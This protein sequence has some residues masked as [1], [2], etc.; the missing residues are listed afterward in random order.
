MKGVYME[1]NNKDRIKKHFKEAEQIESQI[2]DRKEH[3]RVFWIVVTA[4][5][6]LLLAV[7]LAL[8]LVLIRGM[9]F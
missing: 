7:C 6:V 5:I 3:S 2:F 1:Q 4:A 9:G 8:A